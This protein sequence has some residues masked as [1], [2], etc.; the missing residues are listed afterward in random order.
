MSEIKIFNGNSNPVLAQ[1]VASHL[2]ISIGNAVVGRFSDGEIMV[3]ILE[4][5]RG[6]DTFILQ[7]T[8]APANDNLMEMIILADA[9]VE[10]PRKNYCRHSLF[11][12]CATRSSCRLHAFPLLRKWLLI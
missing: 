8:C 2:Q 5:V 3:E 6:R 9:F 1:K 12:L 4:N 7:S 10:R 11:R